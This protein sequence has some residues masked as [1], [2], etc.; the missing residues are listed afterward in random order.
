MLVVRPFTGMRVARDSNL[1][2][3]GRASADAPAD[4]W[5]VD[6]VDRGLSTVDC[7]I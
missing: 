4:S 5:T 2:A 6:A 7:F 3:I 1:D